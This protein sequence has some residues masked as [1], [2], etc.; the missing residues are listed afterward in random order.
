MAEEHTEFSLV[1]LHYFFMLAFKE[2]ITHKMNVNFIQKLKLVS[3]LVVI[4]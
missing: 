1:E 4:I 2:A 3:K